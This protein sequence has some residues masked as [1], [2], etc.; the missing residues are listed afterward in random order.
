MRRSLC[1]VWL[2]WTSDRR[3][4]PSPWPLDRTATTTHWIR[5]SCSCGRR[6][7]TRC[8]RQITC[9]RHHQAVAARDS[10]GARDSTH[11]LRVGG[12]RWR[13]HDGGARIAPRGMN[14]PRR[15]GLRGHSCSSTRFR[16]RSSRFR[17]ADRPSRQVHG[18]SPSGGAER[19]VRT[20]R[21]RPSPRIYG[22]C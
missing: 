12:N 14:R 10:E 16:S 1:R 19:E 22:A 5:R 13:I 2:L 20:A 6:P 9:G 17:V 8:A 4:A 18:G 15:P 3:L 7:A 11:R 21:L